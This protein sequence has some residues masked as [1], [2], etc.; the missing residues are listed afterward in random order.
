MSLFFSALHLIVGEMSPTQELLNPIFEQKEDHFTSNNT[1]YLINMSIIDK[2]YFWIYAEFGQT[3]PYS[4]T[5]YNVESHEKEPNS[6]TLNHIEPNKQLFGLFCL[7]DK[8]LYLSSTQKIGLVEEYLASKLKQSVIIKPLI[9]SAEEFINKLKVVNTIQLIA[10]RSLFNNH[11]ESE[12]LRIFSSQQ[13]LFGLG[14]PADF[15]LEANFKHATKTE[16]FIAYFRK[17]I[18]WRNDAEVESLV[19]IGR[20]DKNFEMIFNIDT[21]LEKIDIQEKKDKFGRYNSTNVQRTI[22]AKIKNKIA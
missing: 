18:G 10:K 13:D 8:V 22:I 6:R 7:S 20:D 4:E 5:L 17:M 15:K 9:K 12:I 2:E 1:H 21:F 16:A 14:M 19:C 11:S 3:H